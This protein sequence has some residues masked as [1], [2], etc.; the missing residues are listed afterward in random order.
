VHHH[1]LCSLA[2]MSTTTHFVSSPPPHNALDDDEPP[3]AYSMTADQWHGESTVEYGPN[4]AF[5]PAPPRLQRV[6]AEVNNTGDVSYNAPTVGS[7]RTPL[8]PPPRHPSISPQI[9]PPVPPARPRMMSDFASAFYESGT[10]E[11]AHQATASI[12]GSNGLN[13]GTPSFVPPTGAPP[14]HTMHPSFSYAPP[15]GAPPS[16]SSWAAP[17]QQLQSPIASS[18]IA[19]EEVPEDGRPTR[20]PI[21]GHPLLNDGRILVYPAGHECIKCECVPSL[22]FL[23]TYRPSPG[24]NTGYKHNDPSQPCRKCWSKHAKP[25]TGVI[26]YAPT[27]PSASAPFASFTA[28]GK[29][30]QRPI[31]TGAPPKSQL[32]GAYPGL[33]HR[34]TVSSPYF[35][36]GHGPAYPSTLHHQQSTRVVSNPYTL[37][38]T[39]FAGGANAGGLPPSGA[40]VVLPGDPRI[41]GMTCWRCQGRG[42]T[43]MLFLDRET[44]SVCGGVGRT[45]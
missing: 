27:T 12:S 33:T 36:P 37:P 14:S 35:P 30:F 26:T 25:Y 8:Q 44:C 42:V 9:T 21:P 1:R 2:L 28:G 13:N 23:F 31:Q 10:G 43:S 24:Q 40:T 5:Q 4:H 16:T 32:M 45:F 29:T 19:H 15:P 3:P 22:M 7:S 38:S 17:P 18:S 20:V 6:Q 39:S 34:R 11:P 41:G